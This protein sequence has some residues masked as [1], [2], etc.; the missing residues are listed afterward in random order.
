MDFWQYYAHIAA[1]REGM[2]KEM[3]A[4]TFAEKQ[5]HLIWGIAKGLGLEE[6]YEDAFGFKEEINKIFDNNNEKVHIDE[7]ANKG[8]YVNINNSEEWVYDFG[9]IREIMNMIDRW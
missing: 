4:Q 9:E 2:K 8:N 7:L 1:F 5:T 6:E 3:I